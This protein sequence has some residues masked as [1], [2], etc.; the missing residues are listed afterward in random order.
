LRIEVIS[1]GRSFTSCSS[2]GRHQLAAQ[3]L[4]AAANAG[5]ESVG[6]NLQDDAPDQ[7]G[8]D[9]AL[10]LDLAARSLL[11]LAQQLLCLLV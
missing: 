7:V 8:V 4:Q 1:S 5:V 11:D 6:S 10:C 2:L 3:P 9:A